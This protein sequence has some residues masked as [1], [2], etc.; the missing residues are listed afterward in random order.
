MHNTNGASKRSR[1]FIQRIVIGLGIV[2]L[3]VGFAADWF[4]IGSQGTKF[5]MGQVSAV[6]IGVGLIV[7]S[8]VL[9][10]KHL[11]RKRLW[12]S[13]QGTVDEEHQKFTQKVEKW[14]IGIFAGVLFVFIMLYSCFLD[15]S[16]ATDEIGLYNPIYMFL[17]YGKMTYPAHLQ[18]DNMV[19]HPPTHYGVVALLM[20]TGLH[21]FHAA[22]LPLILLS[23]ISL[24]LIWSG[25]F[26]AITKFGLMSGLFIGAF[27]WTNF[28]PRPPDLSDI[29]LATIFTIRPDLHLALAWFTG[30]IALE[31]ARLDNWNVLKLFGGGFL[32][33]Y[34]TS[35]HY[36][37]IAIP[38]SLIVYVIWIWFTA[39]KRQRKRMVLTM[40]S[41]AGVFGIPFLCL[42]VLPNITVIFQHIQA[43]EGGKGGVSM[44]LLEYI[45]AY[46]TYREIGDIFTT[47]SPIAAAL[48]IPLLDYHLPAFLVGIT[49]LM[50]FPSM[51]CLTIAS[52]PHILFI[53][54]G[55]TS[56][57]G[58]I[59]YPYKGYYI[60]EFIIYYAGVIMVIL[61]CLSQFFAKLFPQSLRRII[62]PFLG[63]VV[64]G[65]VT[66]D[67]ISNNYTFV[68]QLN[69]LEIA[70]SCGRE[71]LGPDAVIGTNATIV[72]YT[73]GGAKV[74]YMNADILNQSRDISSFE[75]KRYFSSFD[76][77]IAEPHFS[78]V[79]VWWR[80]KGLVSWYQ[81]GVLQLRGFYFGDRHTRHECPLA[82]IVLSPEKAGSR[83]GFGY[84]HHVVYR[85]DENR[86]GDEMFVGY[87]GSAKDLSN[88]IV[89]NLD[90][91]ASYPLLSRDP[92]NQFSENIFFT[93]I[94]PRTRY[95]KLKSELLSKGELQE[96]FPVKRRIIP[97]DLLLEKLHAT[98]RPIEF[99]K[100][101]PG[102]L[103]P[104]EVSRQ[105]GEASSP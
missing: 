36:I 8:F 7:W 55:I 24:F 61:V 60:P 102:K 72:W 26:S 68:C 69:D 23:F 90:F 101:L 88:K 91:F 11:L 65:G 64:A 27:I 80:Q 4:G 99:L 79:A 35:I 17:N 14:S 75:A 59:Y 2:S 94:L 29:D 25:H 1:I 37:G 83:I 100:T 71:M 32:I 105:D 57:V 49:C 6:F 33:A 103:F 97:V 76:A 73:G 53:I 10:L 54:F 34:A 42:W 66:I 84:R 40:I 43:T 15:R 22:G 30:L 77:V 13:E 20:K 18:P 58:K 50:L 45:N 98:D 95:N 52:L 46:G 47:L 86:E 62:V 74:Y 12:I 104:P 85:F 51:R 93:F 63:I 41:G 82:S 87:L 38:F 39:G 92:T 48:T 56:G 19:T 16:P 5:G 9:R 28:I 96:A 70:R 78:S 89:G 81:D 31:S 3:A 44:A 67:I 21:L